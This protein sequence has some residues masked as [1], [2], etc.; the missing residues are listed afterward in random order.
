MKKELTPEERRKIYE[1]I[2]AEMGNLVTRQMYPYLPS[3]NG[4]KIE[5]SM[6]KLRDLLEMVV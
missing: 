5:R 1:D 6:R 3:A 2:F 4:V